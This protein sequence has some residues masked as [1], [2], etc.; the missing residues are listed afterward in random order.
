MAATGGAKAGGKL[1][2]GG[3]SAQVVIVE[4]EIAEP[5]RCTNVVAVIGH[6]KL[7]SVAV[8]AVDFEE[9]AQVLA[10]I[11]ATEAVAAEHGILFPIRHER[12]DLIGVFAHV[13]CRDNRRTLPI[14]EALRDVRHALISFG[15]QAVPALGVE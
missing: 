4:T 11:A 3:I 13:I 9:A 8:M 5:L 14:G 12:A 2:S 1:G 7:N 6:Q 15:M 10:C